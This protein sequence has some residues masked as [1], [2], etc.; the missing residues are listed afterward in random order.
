MNNSPAVILHIMVQ[1]TFKK[2][3]ALFIMSGQFYTH[4]PVIDM[5]ENAYYSVPASHL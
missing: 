4:V 1:M 3:T 5:S 2:K